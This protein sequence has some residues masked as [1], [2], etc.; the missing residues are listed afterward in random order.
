MRT[1]GFWLVGEKTIISSVLYKCIKCR[2]LR[3]KEECPKMADLPFDRLDP[4]PP[5][6][7][8][9]IDVFGPWTIV[10]RKTRGGHANSKRWAVMFTCLVT[11][12]VHIEVIEE[13]SSGCF[14]NALRRFCAIRG[15]VKIIRSD[16]GTNFVG[17]LSDINAN[18]INIDDRPVKDFINDKRINWVFNPPHSSHMGGSWERMI[19]IARRILDSLLLDVGQLTHDILTTFMAEVSAIINA[20][21][22]VPLDSDPEVP[23]PLTPA[24]LLTMKTE[25]TVRC[26]NIEDFNE[27]DLVRNQWK[28]VQQLANSFW[29]RWKTQ[30]LPILQTRPKWKGDTRNLTKGDIVLV[31]DQTL[32]R[33]E[34]PVGIIE[35]VYPSSD[36]RV[37]KVEVRLGTDRKLLKRPATEIVLLLSE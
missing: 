11:R 10:T 19:G 5:F 8:V 4:A 17:A 16:C 29:K 22:L 15:E 37:R 13:M 26:F 34:W 27:K 18:V 3:G 28:C 6:S 30:Y 21:P 7:Y 23:F 32:H 31:K 12:A 24:T 36:G 35:C 14:I 2:K 33:N 1:S 20:R 9:G 25:H